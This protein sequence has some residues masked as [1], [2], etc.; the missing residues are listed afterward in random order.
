MAIESSHRAGKAQSDKFKAL[1]RELECDEDEKAFDK[2][3]ER[4]AKAPPPSD[5][6]RLANLKIDGDLCVTSSPRQT[7]D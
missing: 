4:L 5:D 1:A 7:L 6:T 3:L 2:K